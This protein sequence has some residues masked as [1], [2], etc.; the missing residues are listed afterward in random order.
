MY[1]K[2]ILPTSVQKKQRGSAIVL[3]LFIIVVLSLLGTAMVRML[4]ANAENIVYEVVGTRAYFAAQTGMQRRL[5]EL[6]PL[7]SASAGQCSISNP[8]SY[9][10]NAVNGL[11]NCQA[12]SVTC[13]S[14]TVGSTGITYYTLTSTGQCNVG[15]ITTTR[16]IEVQAKTL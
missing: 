12:S 11:A 16:T 5:H 10:F 9:T 4:G 8:T 6:F 13:D 15:S 1:L 3:A 2:L 14:K 7:N